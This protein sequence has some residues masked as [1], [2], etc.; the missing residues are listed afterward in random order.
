MTPLTPIPFPETSFAL[1]LGLLLLAP[2]AIAGLALIN[3]GLGRSRS[4]MQSLLGS[5]VVISTS[6]IAFA[7]VGS[8]IAAGTSGDHVFHLGGKAWNWAGAG[9][10]FLRGFDTSGPRTQLAVLF[11]L[12]SVALVVLIPWGSG[13]D[14]LRLPA[15]AAIAAIF[16]AV[17]FPL[18]AHWTWGGGWLAQLG[19]NTGQG[20]GLLDGGGAAAIHGL[21][22]VSALALVWIA[23]PRK[24]KFP[25]EGLSTAMPGHN[26]VYVLLGCLIALLGW[27][28]WNMAGSLLWLNAAPVALAETAVNTLLSAAAALVATFSVTRIRFGKPD[29][30][31][32]ANGWMAGLVTSSACAGVVSP[33]AA[34]FAGLVAG[35]LTPL[36]VEL[37]E[38]AL[39]IDDPSGAIS[40]HGAAGLWGLAAA[41]MF[42]PQSGQFVAQLIGVSTLLGLVLPLVYL[43]FWLVN[44]VLVFRVDPD[45]ERL[46]MDLHE[47]GGNAYPEFVVHRDESFR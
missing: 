44:R 1:T 15:G 18:V 16:G 37:F 46:G 21:G 5:L 14:R 17:V 27:L 26:V 10:L 25:R 32:C 31:L 34:L 6:V 24:G 3:T 35:I 45:G 42:A 7:L 12:L 20:S 19:A 2:L 47:L 28:A 40:V 33:L 43:I 23:G 41:G 9:P 8:A 13:A 36:L 39:S 29:A 38:L 4:A 30:S 11:E 22:G